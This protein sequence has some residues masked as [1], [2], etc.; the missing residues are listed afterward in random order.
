MTPPP[1]GR[2]SLRTVAENAAWV[3]AAGLAVKPIW[4]GFLTVL[5]ARVL[6]AEGY[7]ALTTAMS[8]VAIAFSFTGWGVEA[9]VVRE[10]AADPARAPRMFVSFLG[11]R[12]ALVIA[13]VTGA[14]ATGWALGYGPVLLGAVVAACAYQAFTSLGVYAQGFLQALE[15]MRTQGALI[16]TERI[17]T[18]SFGTAAL[19]WWRTP[20]SALAGMAVGAALTALIAVRWLGRGGGLTAGRFDLDVVRA[21]FRPL[22]PFA[23]A[24]FLGVLFFRVD[25]VMVE[26]FLGVAEAGRYGL[27]FRIVEALN[28]VFLAV[29]TALYPRLSQ[30]SAGGSDREIWRVVAAT[31]GAM[32]LACAGIAGAVALGARPAIAWAIADPELLAAADVLVVLCWSLPLTAV[33]TLLNTTLV[34]RGD[35]RFVALALA[36]GVALNV[37]ANAALIP[38]L[39]TLGAVVTTIGSET[40]LLAV[41]LARLARTRAVSS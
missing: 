3:G 11:L 1:S 32:A 5:C 23:A 41:Y 8:L 35:Q 39:G 25:A 16:V 10:V 12:T 14:C 26:G 27:A 9:Y 20:A 7:G 19:L 24:G 21:A 36:G 38:R 17:L 22:V 15:R 6:G 34:A 28:M 33:R 4:F 37:A 31:T 13:A 2:S 29:N 30:L 18:V 40:V